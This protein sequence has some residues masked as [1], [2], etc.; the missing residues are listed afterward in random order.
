[1]REHAT[2]FR[3]ALVNCTKVPGFAGILATDFERG[4]MAVGHAHEGA[5]ADEMR[6]AFGIFSEPRPVVTSDPDVFRAR[7]KTADAAA[8]AVVG[9]IHLVA[10]FWHGSLARASAHR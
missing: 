7:R 10:R 2:D 8:L 3:A 4:A 9:E 6:E 1:S 5:V